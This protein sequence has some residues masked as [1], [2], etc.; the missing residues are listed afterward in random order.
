MLV[1]IIADGIQHANGTPCPKGTEIEHPD[2]WRLCGPGPRNA[3]PI[4]EPVDDEAKQKVADRRKE[5]EPVVR[6]HLAM[7]QAN[8]DKLARRNP[9]WIDPETGK[10]K[11]GPDGELAFRTK[12]ETVN[13]IETAEAHGLTPQIDSAE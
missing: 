11:R 3:P 8:I 5:R 12:N 13:L 9:K 4:A 7:M 10:F 6:Q 1:R 2:A